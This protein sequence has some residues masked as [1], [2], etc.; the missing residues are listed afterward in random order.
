MIEIP[1]IQQPNQELN[2]V[3]NDQ[4]C[5]IQIKQLGDYVYLSL[6]LDDTLI[7]ESAICMIGVFILQ[8][9]KTAFN[10]NFVFIDDTSPANDQSQP[11]YKQFDDRFKLYYVTDD[12]I[13][14]NELD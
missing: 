14:A 11:D 5:T 1:L 3:L 9:A 12:E 2:I 13:S 10:G 7:R 6:W 4:S 8:G